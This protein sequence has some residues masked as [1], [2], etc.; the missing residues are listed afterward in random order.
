M[1]EFEK[2]NSVSANSWELKS[3]DELFGKN[4]SLKSYFIL[5]Q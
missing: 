5:I 4:S 3:G 1:S 2:D